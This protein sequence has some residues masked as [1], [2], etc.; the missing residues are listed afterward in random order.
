MTT[1][2][3]REQRHF[4]LAMGAPVRDEQDE[5]GLSRAGHVDRRAVEARAVQLGDQRADCGIGTG[6]QLREGVTDDLDGTRL[7]DTGGD[8][9]VAAAARDDDRDHGGEDDDRAECYP[10]GW[11]AA[12]VGRARRS[13][14]AAR[15]TDVSG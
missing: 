7:L 9:V 1:Q 4:A 13:A 14:V 11:D 15:L 12:A 6:A 8:R 5:L 10:D 3:V 2:V